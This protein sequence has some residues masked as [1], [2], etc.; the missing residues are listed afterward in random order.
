MLAGAA[1]KGVTEAIG[2]CTTQ[3]IDAV[4][5]VG[6]MEGGDFSLDFDG[7]VGGEIAALSAAPASSDDDD[8]EGSPTIS[9]MEEPS[10]SSSDTSEVIRITLAVAPFCADRRGIFRSSLRFELGDAADVLCLEFLEDNF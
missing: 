2:C 4:P 3:K 1:G 5:R 8:D 9:M 6:V 10:D 7:V